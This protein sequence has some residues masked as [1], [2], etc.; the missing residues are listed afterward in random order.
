METDE[1]AIN[2]APVEA[3]TVFT[4]YIFLD[5]VHFTQNR[6]VEA[7]TNIVEVLN[8]IVRAAISNHT[9]MLD[10]CIFLPTGDGMC[11]AIMG[12]SLP[13]DIHLKIALSILELVA[14]HTS[15][16]ESEMRKFRIRIGLNQNVDNVVVDIDGRKNLAGA[17]INIAARVMSKAD[18]NQLLVSDAVYDTLQHREKYMGQF[19]TFNSTVKH[20]VPLRFHQYVGDN[21]AGLNTDPPTELKPKQESEPKFTRHLAYYLAHA[22]RHKK[23]ILDAINNHSVGEYAITM[24]LWMLANASVEKSQATE[25]RPYSPD[26]DILE[27]DFLLQIKHFDEVEYQVTSLFNELLSDYVFHKYSE[28]LQGGFNPFA[29][30][31]VTDKGIE[32]LRRDAP[33]IWK[34]LALEDYI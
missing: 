16:I 6:S 33:R 32:K 17:G 9:V 10:A 14:D 1:Q 3:Q 8:G 13:Y 11:I 23:D 15:K 19:A 27:Q 34:E 4:K 26:F 2:F 21:H 5:V 31:F 18:G 7:Q 22:I 20:N 29:L 24:N 28:Y 30:L 12:E 25:V